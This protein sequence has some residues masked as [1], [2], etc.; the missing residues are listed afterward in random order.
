M[1]VSE[2]PFDVWE[3]FD[4][5]SR[6]LKDQ[7]QRV[8]VYTHDKFLHILIDNGYLEFNEDDLLPTHI[9]HYKFYRLTDKFKNNCHYDILEALTGKE[10][11]KIKKEKV[12]S[13]VDIPGD[14][15]EA[16]EALRDVSGYMDKVDL[17][18]ESKFQGI[19]KFHGFTHGAGTN[20]HYDAGS[21]KLDDTSDEDV[22][23]II[24]GKNKKENDKIIS[25][26]FKMQEIHKMNETA[27][28]Y[29]YIVSS[30][31]GREL[32]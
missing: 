27:R 13:I 20:G 15:E 25:E 29:G 4:Y 12:I 8:V 17:G 9:D 32:V 2:I 6:T 28:K 16:L 22:L 19:L 24:T 21:D 23:A 18:S 7:D 31:C 5:L 26:H 1:E 3:K 11:I 14:W 10:Y 30:D